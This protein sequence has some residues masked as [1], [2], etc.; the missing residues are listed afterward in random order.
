MLSKVFVIL[1]ISDIF[2]EGSGIVRGWRL[3]EFLGKGN[4]V[5]GDELLINEVKVI[6]FLLLFGDKLFIVNNKF[7]Y[8]WENKVDVVWRISSNKE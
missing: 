7:F 6:V 2:G 3:W 8:L 4:I 5:F 1:L